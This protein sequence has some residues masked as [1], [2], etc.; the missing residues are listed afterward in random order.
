MT[1]TYEERNLRKL[2][3]ARTWVEDVLMGI[4]PNEYQPNDEAIAQLSNLRFE[5][6]FEDRFLVRAVLAV[7]DQ[8]FYSH[9]GIDPI[10]IV[11]AFMHNVGYFYHQNLQHI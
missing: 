5:I 10:G 2:E 1:E 8:R 6:F 4:C 9:F 3:E 11:S 7:E